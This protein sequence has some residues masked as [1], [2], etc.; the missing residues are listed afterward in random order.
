VNTV[1]FH[2]IAGHYFCLTEKDFDIFNFQFRFNIGKIV[3]DVSYWIG[4]TFPSLSENKKWTNIYDQGKGGFFIV[5]YENGNKV[6]FWNH[7]K[8]VAEEVKTGSIKRYASI[9]L[10]IN[11]ETKDLEFI[12]ES[13]GKKNLLKS[14]RPQKW[15]GKINPAVGFYGKNGTIS[16]E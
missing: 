4:F 13:E 1:N 8:V 7:E 16:V 12:I 6:N 9:V 11:F 5:I 3:P 2:I 14:I 10:R 15:Y